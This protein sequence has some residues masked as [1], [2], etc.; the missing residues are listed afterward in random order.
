MDVPKLLQSTSSVVTLLQRQLFSLEQ[1]PSL[2]DLV[3]GS[4]PAA[5]RSAVLLP[6]FEADGR[7]HLLFIKRA[8][9]LRAHSGEVAFPGGKVDPADL[10]LLA[11]AL[12]E[13]YE[14]VGIAPE[15]IVPLGVL[16]PV[17][18][19]VSNYMITPVVGFLPDGLEP[20]RV[21][22][23]EVSEVIV[24]P[25]ASLA[26][27]AILHTEI[28]GKSEHARTIHFYA[29]GTYQIWGATGRILAAL[30]AKLS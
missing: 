9:T 19:V 26:D 11:T 10:S 2:V 6:L 16:P 30:L 21:H 24:A 13:T 4:Q 12:R 3:E 27:P 15:R 17:F 7:P 18:T 25:L 5:R 1:A 29:Y 28:W 14:E 23:A 20:L 8:A 22:A